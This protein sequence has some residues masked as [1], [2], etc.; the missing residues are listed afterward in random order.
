[1]DVLKQQVRRARRRLAWQ[2]FFAILGWSWFAWLFA[3]TAV[4]TVDKFKPLGLVE[5]AWPVAALVGGL[6]TAT[7][8]CFA[9]RRSE[10]EAAI[11]IDRRFGLKER[12]SSTY[13]LGA[14]QL[15]TPAGRALVEDAMKRVERLHVAEQFRVKLGRWSWL[16]ALPGLATFLIAVFLQPGVDGNK[17]GGSV[18]TKAEKKQVKTSTAAL[19]KK[20][21]DLRKEARDKGL[22]SEGVF[23]KLEQS[24][25]KL[26]NN[27]AVDK[28]QALIELNDLA[29]DVEKR[30]EQV[31][32][33]EKM[34]EQFK[35]LKDL[36][37]GPADKMADAL[38]DG[39]FQV[40]MKEL[41]QLRDK[42]E[43]GKLDAEAKAALEKQLKQMENTL[44]KMADAHDKAQQNLKKQIEELKKKG[45]NQQAKELEEKLAQM[46][47]QQ[48]QMQLA[49]QMADQ[50]GQCTKCMQQG[51]KAGAS[52]AMAKLEQ[53]LS[54]LQQQADEMAMLDD[55]MS[56][57]EM[58]KDSINCKEC[59]GEGCQACMGMGQNRFGKPG[60]GMGRG[61]GTGPRP[62]EKTDS[63][64]YDTKV[65]QQTGKGA[66]LVVDFVNGPNMKGQVQQQIQT[67]FE[68][69]KTEETD[70]LT[71]QQLP[72]GY[73]EHTQKYFDSL[74]EDK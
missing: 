7:I 23:A 44:R 60:M 13:A 11:E 41:K 48:S 35:Q 52:Q 37:K 9:T 22:L 42:L 10:L 53:Q 15:E 73:R 30:R 74:R 63:K 36:D 16:P 28:K 34:K 33:A 4:V 19:R 12:V 26:E 65:K 38:K 43:N 3:A 45:Q 56:E 20:S 1:M 67:E 46:Q 61:R 66:A 8:W 32:A 72:R 21:L 51:D 68:S 70:P 69:V 17:A 71:G 64:F 25:K 24:S 47:Q 58:A 57:L 55:A 5:W 14:E 18:A 54:D 27:D 49:K 50:M 62:E 29:K 59:N 2:R 6:V 40:A 31:A 39:D